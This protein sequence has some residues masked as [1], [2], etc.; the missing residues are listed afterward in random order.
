MHISGEAGT[1][2][3]RIIDALRYLSKSWGKPE[4]IC[5]VAPTGIAAVLI[6]GETVHSKFLINAKTVSKEKERKEI[7]LWSKVLMLVWDEIS[8]TG[9]SLFSTSFE[10]L[11]K[12]LSTPLGTDPRIHVLTAGDFAQLSPCFEKYLFEAP[13]LSLYS[14][15]DGLRKNLERHSISRYSARKILRSEKITSFHLWRTFDAV[16]KLEENMRHRNDPDYGKLLSRLRVGQ[17]TWED[18][19][20]LNKRYIDTSNPLSQIHSELHQIQERVMYHFLFPPKGMIADI[21]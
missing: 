7:E 4:A 12:F 19:Q 3:S 2:K 9:Q 6:D 11:R 1:G 5:T 13:A 10:K 21:P 16:V 8:M 18:F 20:T 14:D 15:G 17:H